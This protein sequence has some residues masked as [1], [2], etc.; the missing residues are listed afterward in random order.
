MDNDTIA[1][2]L[3][4]I[5]DLLA[6]D[7]VPHERLLAHREAA[8]RIR[9]SARRVADLIEEDGVEGLHALG[10]GYLICGLIT[11]WVRT[12]RLQLLEQL[13]SRH[14]PETQLRRVPGI[15]PGLART[16]HAV[17]VDSIDQLG[18]AAEDGRLS[19]VCGFGPRRVEL[20]LGAL[21]SLMPRR[22]HRRPVQLTL[23]IGSH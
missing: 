5:A 8:R 23:S 18:D 20:V 2:G 12:G 6:L 1:L 21:A 7:G 22:G 4:R 16:L 15:G 11:D 17:G 13:Q 9:D 10:I 19:N 14:M 3:E